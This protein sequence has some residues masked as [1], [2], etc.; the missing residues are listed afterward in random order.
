MTK[1]TV[2]LVGNPN[3]GK[4][5]VFNVLTS[6][7]Q[8]I[9]NWPGVTVDRKTGHWSHAGVSVETADLPGVYTLICPTQE[10]AI[11]AKIA[12]DFMA[13]SKPDLIINSATVTRFLSSTNL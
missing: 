6:S 10:H 13:Y 5:T 1:L 7:N 9:G 2:A 3:C 4:T 11:D 12:C 8:S